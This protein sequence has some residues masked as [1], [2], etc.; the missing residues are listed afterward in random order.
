MN[1]ARI[2]NWIPYLLIAASFVF[3]SLRMRGFI[4]RQAVNILF[5]D[6]WDFLTPLF[7]NPTAWE[8]FTRQHGPHRQGLGLFV[9]Q[10]VGLASHW[11]TRAECAVIG[12]ILVLVTIAAL[13]LKKRLFG[14]LTGWDLLIP[15][16]TL[17]YTQ[18]ETVVL[19]PNPA[20]GA[21][22][23][24]LVVISCLILTLENIYL[25]YLGLVFIT[26]FATYTGFGFFLGVVTPVVLFLCVLIHWINKEK[27]S[28]TAAGIALFLSIVS[29]ASFF[30]NYTFSSVQDCYQSPFTKFFD[31]L[32]FI[33][34]ELSTF[35]G[36]FSLNNIW[37]ATATG[38][39]ALIG[40]L[41]VLFAQIWQLWKKRTFDARNLVI[42]LLISFSLLFAINSTSGRI[43]NG[44]AGAQSSRY[45][46]LLIPGFLGLYFAAQNLSQKY[47]RV[48]LN[49]FLI[50][51]FIIFPVR[52]MSDFD[53]GMGHFAE[54]KKAWA[55]CYR[56]RESIEGCNQIV[57]NII[58]PAPEAT[59]MK[60]K[61]GMLKENRYN[62]F[63]ENEK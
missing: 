1:R 22:P 60:E 14:N 7:G 26:F 57:G 13:Y 36:F 3:F 50:I 43:C 30:I 53:K 18:I 51:L 45:M 11:N 35:F 2:N 39:L 9:S 23:I 37:L 20:H 46:T 55:E 29:F 42:F 48:T 24:L 62:L 19:T 17:T 12:L 61:L 10:A 4:R 47:R 16:I 52:T 6:Q 28:M 54:V 15:A 58:Y 31:Y 44:L 25:R 38:F 49:S 8:M 63:V 59:N 27:T 5:Y 21:L 56:E 32:S 34:L 41:S 33:S 40:L